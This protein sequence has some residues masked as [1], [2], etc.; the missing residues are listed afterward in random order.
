MKME[1]KKELTNIG[2]A[3]ILVIGVFAAVMGI[4]S[5]Q[6]YYNETG[7]YIEGTNVSVNT[8]VAFNMSLINVPL[9]FQINNTLNPTA[10]NFS[11]ANQSGL[12]TNAT[13]SM[14]NDSWFWVNASS[15]DT[16]WLNVSNND[17][18]SEYVNFTVEYS[19]PPVKYIEGINVSVNTSEDFNRSY[20][21]NPL[22]FQ[23]NN[24]LNESATS[25]NVTNQSGLTTNATGRIL[26]ANE[27][28][29]VNASSAD[30]YW[31]NVSNNE[32][33]S[34]YVNFTVEYSVFPPSPPQEIT[35]RIKP[36]T[37]NLGSKG[38]FTAIITN[39]NVTAI[40][41]STVKCE[42][43]PAVKGMIDGDTF[44]AKFNRQDLVDVQT[45]DDNVTLTVTGE[46]NDGTPFEGNDTIRVINKGRW[47]P[48]EFV[49]G[50][51]F[52]GVK[53]WAEGV[54]KKMFFTF[55]GDAKA[56]LQVDKDTQSKVPVIIGFKDTPS[57]ADKNMIRGH[58]GDIKHSYTIINA[59]AAKLPEQAIDKIKKNP[60]VAY[61]EMDGEVHALDTE[62]D[63]SWG[64]KRIGAGTVHA[65]NNGTG[66]RVA[67]IDT[68][69]DYTHSDLGANYKDGYDY[70]NDDA[71]PMD[72]N[73]HGTHCAGIVA[74][75]D[76]GEGVVGVAPKAHL[77][78]VKVL[79]SSGSGSLSDVIAGIQW[80][81]NNGMDV[82]SMSLG[83]DFGSISLKNACNNASSSGVLLVAAAGNDGNPSGKGDTVDYPARYDSVIAVAAT[84]SNDERARWSST[85]PD[86]E[87]AAPGVSIYSTRLGGGYETKSGTSMACPH[88]SGTAA[89]VIASDSSLSNDEVR[90][91]LQET[92]DDLGA[93]GFDTRYGYGLV[94]AVE[95]ASQPDTTPPVPTNTMHVD[96]ITVSTDSRSAGPKNTFVW[97]VATVTIVDNSGNSVEGATVSGYW[98]NAT[99]D[100]DSGV[101]DANGQ[102][103]L[104]SDSVKNPSGGTT[105]TFTVDNVAKDGWTYNSSANV[106]TSDSITVP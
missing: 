88:V 10:V 59:I 49:S 20:I 76:N 2:L 51:W 18:Q 24:T 71:D 105:F 56:K 9:T 33:R 55:D 14:D 30:T 70:V 29:W 73:G 60:K 22:T 26:S 93:A 23:I 85:G 77:Y 35:I 75:E 61:V 57:Q 8:S 99:R 103:S 44:I 58:S 82:I 101:T 83:S 90:L 41:I 38:V 52:Y 16:Y 12:T 50:Q 3:V 100:S 21:N 31:V 68:G 5:A 47:G 53:K 11:V 42:G 34:E 66:V 79:D 102:V 7:N 67:I 78:A 95:A 40:N 1:K 19:P 106:K 25:F 84:D 4:A 6:T 64:V 74:A 97:A 46:L 63:N 86:V 92:A 69:I 13:D 62:L 17:N 94:D 48:T 72:D 15:A 39:V 91:L 87:L 36:E 32:N 43:A 27:W 45:T 37:L 81:Q 54:H 89:L 98:S 80:S 96:N 104:E 28:F 65:D